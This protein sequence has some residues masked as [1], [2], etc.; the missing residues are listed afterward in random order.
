MSFSFQS[1]E[2]R[3]KSSVEHTQG[4]IKKLRTGRATASV[5]D[6]VFVEAYGTRM[7]VAEVASISTPDATLLVISPWDKSLIEAIEKAIQGADLNLHPVVDGQIVRI[8]VPSL[9]EENRKLLVKKL[10]Q[11]VEAGRVAIRTARSEAKR[12]IEEQKGTMGVS[13]DDIASSVDELETRV[14]KVLE[15]LDAVLQKKEQELLTL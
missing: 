14:H 2:E 10:H 1:F 15:D 4:E 13:E 12:Q 6:D 5:L 8:A 7:R 9:T 11:T 3:L